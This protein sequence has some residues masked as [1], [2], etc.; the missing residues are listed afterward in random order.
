MRDRTAGDVARAD[1][2][3]GAV[4]DGCEETGERARIVR[5][6]RVD[7]HEHL[8]AA[9]HAEREAGAVRVA[10]PD[11]LRAPQH[12]DA[13]ESGAGLLGEI[14]GPVRAV[15]VDDEY[16]DVG[17]GRGASARGTPRCSPPRGRSA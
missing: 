14:R 11:L 9:V 17:R 13:A 6:V 7:L 10:Q 8:V 2:E 15:V 3:I 1:G 5:Q 16:V 12:V 4:F